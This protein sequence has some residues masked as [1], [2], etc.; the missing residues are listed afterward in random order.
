MNVKFSNITHTTTCLSA[1]LFNICL[2]NWLQKWKL[3][4][5]ETKSSH[6]TFTLRKDNCPAITINQTVLPKVESVKY[7]GL[8]FDR[9][10]NW[11]VHIT[12]KRKQTDFKAK[13][14]NWLIGKKSNLSIENKIL[15]YKAVIKSIWTYGIELWGCASKSNTAIMQRAQ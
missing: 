12:K 8:H 10:L 15:V 4:V 1:L 9:R 7:L 11:K 3:K 14:I 2:K 6:T 5:N 13:E